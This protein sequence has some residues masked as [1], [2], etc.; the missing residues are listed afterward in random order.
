MKFINNFSVLVPVH[1]RADI[2][3]LFDKSII[4]IFNNTLLPKKVFVLIDGLINLEFTKKISHYKK[5][6]NFYVLQS[7]KKIGLAKILNMGINNVHSEWIIR[8]DADDYNLPNRFEKLMNISNQKFDLIGSQVYET[9]LKLNLTVKKIVPQGQN[10]IITMLKYKNPFNHMSV[11]F[12]TK[13][14]KECGGYPDISLKEDYALWANMISRGAKVKNLNLF[15]VNA[16]TGSHMYGRRSGINHI[17]AEIKLQ[18][19]LLKIGITNIFFSMFI[20][21]IRIFFYI[22]PSSLK[23]FFYIFFLR[24]QRKHLFNC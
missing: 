2:F 9:D 4:S 23:Y 15:L 19:Y 17:I 24:K 3:L 1:Q 14:V 20:G 5:K 11:A 13:F 10:A 6:F 8:A 7:K 21:L 22:T 12:K 18:K 16:N